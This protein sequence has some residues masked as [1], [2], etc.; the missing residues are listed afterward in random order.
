MSLPVASLGAA[1]GEALTYSAAGLPPGLAVAKGGTVTGTVAKAA[2]PKA[3]TT[4]KVTVSV[5]NATGM[6]ATA[7][8]SWRVSPA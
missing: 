3:A 7:A 1:A 5:K 4:Y 6:T 8:F 2:A